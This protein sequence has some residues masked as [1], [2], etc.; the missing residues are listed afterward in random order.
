MNYILIY[1][2]WWKLRTF[3]LEL[4]DFVSFLS[5]PCITKSVILSIRRFG[6]I[7]ILF[8]KPEH[9]TFFDLFELVCVSSD[10]IVTA[11]GVAIGWPQTL[12]SSIWT[13]SGAFN[14]ARNV[15]I[16]FFTS[17]IIILQLI[18][19]IIN[20]WRFK[21]KKA[22]NDVLALIRLRSFARFS[23]SFIFKLISIWDK[24][25]EQMRLSEIILL[26]ELI[27]RTFNHDVAVIN[28]LQ[29]LAM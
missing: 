12:E 15:G 16:N 11:G 22:L 17:I 18:I 29:V 9:F 2:T 8:Q 7:F 14:L 4:S 6:L 3:C 26:H 24:M 21:P 20:L 10:C 13:L 1:E 23:V 5:P 19:R 27:R 28:N 25:R